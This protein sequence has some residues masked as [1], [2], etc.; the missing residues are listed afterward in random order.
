MTIQLLRI[1]DV[2]AKISY[3]RSR[4]YDWIKQ[5]CFP[6]PR[7]IMGTNVWRESDIDAWIEEKFENA[8]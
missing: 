4:I 8:G 5:G 2:E 1:A 7:K 3:S 6:Q